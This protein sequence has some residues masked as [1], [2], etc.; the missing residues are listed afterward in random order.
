MQCSPDT[1]EIAGAYPALERVDLGR[2]YARAEI[3]TYWV[4]DYPARVIEVFTQ[5]SGPIDSPHYSKRDRYP[6]G[7]NVPLVL[8]GGTVGTVA[9]ADVL[10]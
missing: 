4:L 5:P 2:I 10:G 7:T 8:D 1:T 3:P 9:V 6:V